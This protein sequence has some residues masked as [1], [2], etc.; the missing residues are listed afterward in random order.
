MQ[1]RKEG[2]QQERWSGLGNDG[3][4]DDGA[5]GG[6]RGNS[7]TRFRKGARS[8]E[9]NRLGAHAGG[10]RSYIPKG[11]AAGASAREDRGPTPW[12]TCPSA[13]GRCTRCKWQLRMVVVQVPGTPVPGRHTV[14]MSTIAR[15]VP[16]STNGGCHYCFRWLIISCPATGKDPVPRGCSPCYGF[17]SSTAIDFHSGVKALM[18]TGRRGGK[19]GG[20]TSCP[21]QLD[22]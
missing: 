18:G 22:V 8:I 13:E 20:L 16:L 21:D 1:E 14:C 4:K 7:M 10:R 6:R 12:C 19:R 11:A 2:V 15:S 9:A 17:T 3:K 5:M